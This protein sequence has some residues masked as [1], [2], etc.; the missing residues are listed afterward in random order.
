MWELSMRRPIVL[1]AIG[2]LT[3][4]GCSKGPIPTYAVQGKVSFAD[5]KPLWG[6]TIE[7]QPTQAVS[8]DQMKVS[9]RGQ[10]QQDGMYTLSTFV[11]GDGAP[12]GDHRV[13]IIQPLPPGKIN[14]YN[15]SPAVIDSKFQSYETSGLKFT[16]TPE[17][18]NK[19][20]ITVSPPTK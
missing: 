17:G 3:L 15:P 11:P 6:G 5:G 20:D 18:P 9:S 16:V 8:S 4:P 19:F 7:F 2:L 10:I 14:P 12:A 13:L 1:L